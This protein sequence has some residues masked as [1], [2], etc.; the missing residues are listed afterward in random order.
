M[1]GRAVLHWGLC[2]LSLCL[3]SDS[4]TDL[5]EEALNHEWNQNRLKKKLDYLSHKCNSIPI[6]KEQLQ[7]NTD[8]LLKKENNFQEKFNT[9]NNLNDQLI[10]IQQDPKYL[11]EAELKMLKSRLPKVATEGN[12]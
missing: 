9:A 2:V 6:T 3:V 8:Y 7:P 5:K 1:K 11:S 10:S 12:N 4:V